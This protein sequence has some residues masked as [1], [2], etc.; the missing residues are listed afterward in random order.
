M[1]HGKRKWWGTIPPVGI[2]GEWP[3]TEIRR[4]PPAPFLRGRDV[5]RETMNGYGELELPCPSH[6]PPRALDGAVV[7]CPDTVVP[8]DA[9]VPC[10][11]SG[12][13]APRRGSTVG[14]R[15]CTFRAREKLDLCTNH[16]E[17]TRHHKTTQHTKP[18]RHTTN[19]PTMRHHLSKREGSGRSHLCLSQLVWHREELSLGP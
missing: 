17:P 4:G 6:N 19:E 13:T 2:R 8:R 10:L 1:V 18:E 5:E 15:R 7:P 11:P 16:F 14:S 3:E 9:V 12:S